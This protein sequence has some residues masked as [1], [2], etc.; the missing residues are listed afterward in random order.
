M[1]AVA[2]L[3]SN[4]LSLSPLNANRWG[5]RRLS[6]RGLAAP[7]LSMPKGYGF[8]LGLTSDKSVRVAGV[9]VQ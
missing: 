4:P 5:L 2:R 3:L 1:N 7:F 9:Q 8:F 6:P